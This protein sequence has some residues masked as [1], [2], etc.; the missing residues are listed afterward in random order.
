V[1]WKCLPSRQ[2]KAESLCL[3]IAEPCREHSP[4]SSAKEQA[5]VCS[6][7]RR[8]QIYCSRLKACF[9][10]GL[11]PKQKTGPTGWRQFHSSDLIGHGNAACPIFP[12]KQR[13]SRT[14]IAPNVRH[15]ARSRDPNPESKIQMCFR[16]ASRSSTMRRI[17]P[18]QSRSHRPTKTD[19]K[20]ITILG[21]RKNSYSFEKHGAQNAN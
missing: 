2:K 12:V 13:K 16:S 10:C 6:S 4:S 5:R 9:W 18:S 7:F 15:R 21:T 1:I 11:L 19:E 17:C 20:K 8:R 14:F 3:T